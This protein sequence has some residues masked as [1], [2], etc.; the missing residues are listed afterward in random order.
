[1]THP[2]DR[3]VLPPLQLGRTLDQ[4]LLSFVEAR[5]LVQL[6]F[7]LRFLVGT[8]LAQTEAESVRAAQGGVAWMCAVWFVY[9]LN[10]L[11][12]VAGDRR[13][14]SRRPLATN[15]L[16]PR[17]AANLCVVLAAASIAVGILV[18]DGYVLLV[19]AMLALGLVYSTGPG[20]AKLSAQ[21]AL[22]VAAAG[23]TLTYIAGAE[24]VGVADSSVLAFALTTGAWI[25]VVGHCKDLGDEDGDRQS[26]RRT[27]SIVVGRARARRLIA[28]GSVVVACLAAVVASV[29]PGTQSL[30]LML[31]GA[32]AVVALTIRGAKHERS[33]QKGLYRAFM[34]VQYAVNL[35]ALVK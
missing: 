13:N 5:P 25:V 17:F 14:G 10:G 2:S 6:V 9:L 28:V 23:S 19:V 8:A 26:G 21:P 32:V 29:V 11:T 7:L 31:P 3:V 18:G 12:D 34:L 22:L 27:L 35:G 16:D 1:M 20:A 33:S 15:E 4:L 24:A 30:L